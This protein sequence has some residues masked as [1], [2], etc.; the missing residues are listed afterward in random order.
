MEISRPFEGLKIIELASVLAGPAAGMF[1]AEL[2]A[3]VIKVENPLTGGDVTRQ[4]KLKVENPEEKTSAYYS[5]INW[6]KEV[7]FIDISTEQG[8][9]KLFELLSDT[10]ILIVNFKSGDAE[11][12]E[13]DYSS[14]SIKFPEL[15]Y[16]HISGYGEHDPRPA[17][18]LVMQAE[19]GFMSMNGTSESG[20]LKMPVAMIDLMAAHQ[21]KEGILTSLLVRHKTGKGSCVLVSLF[22][23][24][25]SSLAN[26][27]SNF[28]IAGF[29][30]SLNG[31]L[32]PNIAPYGETFLCNDEHYIVLAIGND[33]QFKNLC[34][35]FEIPSVFE[36]KRFGSNQSRI[37]CRRELFELLKPFFSKFSSSEM[38]KLLSKSAVPFAII[39]NLDEVLNSGQAQKLILDGK[40]VKTVGFTIRD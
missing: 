6:G 7:L 40:C 26:Q 1:F 21:L 39:R 25:I 30:P 27:A 4:W 37:N 2:G 38:E 3:E 23:A 11:K 15:I 36:D 20:P 18:D 17:F 14:L 22:D 16:A 10:D 13:L 8:K 28:L 12:F 33:N 5:S 35:A 19:T 31:S 29:I 34:N 24:A 9:E 32:H